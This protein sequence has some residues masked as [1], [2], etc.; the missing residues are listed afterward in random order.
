[1]DHRSVCQYGNR[2]FLL[3][4]LCLVL[5]FTLSPCATYGQQVESLA[6]KMAE[7]MARL[8]SGSVLGEDVDFVKNAGAAQAVL[9]DLE[10]AFGRETDLHE[11][12]I[13]ASA[14]VKLGDKDK[15]YWNF[16]L[17]QATL[18]V[19][20]DI[21]DSAFSPSQ[22]KAIA[23]QLSPELLA[24]AAAHHVD[25]NTAG[26]NSRYDYPGK[27]LLLALAEDPR[28]IPLLR[29]ALQSHNLIIVLFAARG[30]AQIQDKDSIPLIIAMCEDTPTFAAALAE[31]ALLYFDDSRAQIAVD[32][33]VDKER[34]RIFRDA[35]AHGLKAL[36]Y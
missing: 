27:V 1:M 17:E 5:C 26:I 4:A 9:P 34:A 28:G 19:D 6:H 29:R 25:A 32:K 21:P 3:D 20:S 14:L 2:L 11:K 7:S 13:I 8:K 12:G 16:L 18:A 10:Q 36:G 33:Y 35:R 24:W 30:L 31:A 15:T 23:G 22:K